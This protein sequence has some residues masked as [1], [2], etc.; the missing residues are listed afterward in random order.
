[1]AFT[2][3]TGGTYLPPTLFFP[4][5]EIAHKQKIRNYN[6]NKIY[7][8]EPELKAMSCLMTIGE[9]KKDF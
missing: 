6:I 5:K 3:G 8:I 4:R 9:T 1:M 2:L 7:Q